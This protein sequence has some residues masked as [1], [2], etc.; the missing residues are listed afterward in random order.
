MNTGSNMANKEYIPALPGL[1][2]DFR[3]QV[4]KATGELKKYEVE[5]IMFHYINGMTIDDCVACIRRGRLL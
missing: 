1:Y 2:L 3:T 4:I 5:K